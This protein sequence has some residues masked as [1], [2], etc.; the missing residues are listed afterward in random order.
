M[1]EKKAMKAVLFDHT[2]RT[3]TYANPATRLTWLSWRSGSA[4]SFAAFLLAF[5]GVGAASTSSLPSDPL[6]A[7]KIHVTEEIISYT[8][9][10]SMDRVSYDITRLE[11]RLSELIELSETEKV[12]PDDLQAVSERI[13]DYI[14]NVTSTIDNMSTTTYSHQDRI[15]T[16]SRIGSIMEAHGELVESTET[17]SSL[18]NE[19]SEAITTAHDSLIT[20]VEQFA[21]DDSSGGVEAYLSDQ[22]S[23]LGSDIASDS[24]LPDTQAEAL[25]SLNDADDSLSEGR[26]EDALI[27]VLDAKQQIAVDKY[28]ASE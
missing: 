25:T 2:S 19:I 27:S 17:L 1:S 11:T 28:L 4:L 3:L 15:S 13:D 24:L 10:N 8:K 12:S 26:T 7:V 22:I 20:A 16:L 9:L 14:E 21:S 23:D 5:V 18:E 6:Y